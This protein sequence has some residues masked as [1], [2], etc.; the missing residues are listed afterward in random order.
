MKLLLLKNV[1]CN[2]HVDVL[3]KCSFRYRYYYQ[4]IEAL[5]QGGRGDMSPPHLKSRVTS[6]VLVIPPTFTTTFILI[7]WSPLHTKSF[8]CPYQYNVTPGLHG[9]EPRSNGIV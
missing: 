5:Q 9:R 7:G 3:S 6:Y 4:Y 1:Y 8:Q 2:V